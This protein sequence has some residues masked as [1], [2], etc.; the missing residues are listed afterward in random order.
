MEILHTERKRNRRS[1]ET[2]SSN[3]A[4]LNVSNNDK[5]KTRT[6]VEHQIKAYTHT[7]ARTLILIA[8]IEYKNVEIYRIFNG[9][10]FVQVNRKELSHSF[11]IVSRFVFIPNLNYLFS[12]VLLSCIIYGGK[13][14]SGHFYHYMNK[15]KNR[16]KKNTI[17]I[18]RK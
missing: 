12:V 13:C 1:K 8:H 16:R 15:Q 18:Q 4:G 7:R 10:H 9:A 5:A 3:R 11:F 2:D 14:N 6:R 17:E